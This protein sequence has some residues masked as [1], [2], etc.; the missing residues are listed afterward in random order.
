[1]CP[2]TGASVDW[3]ALGV[4]MYEMMAGQPPFEA[5]NEDDLFESILHDDV[6]YPVWLSKDA[7]S[8][9]KGFMTKNPSKRLGCVVA[10]GTEA[11]IRTHAFFRDMDWTALENRRVKPPFKP[12]I[13][14]DKD[15]REYSECSVCYGSLQKSKKDA[16]NF[17]AEFTKEDPVLT[18]V[19]MDV[20]RSINQEEFK[21][22]SFINADFNPARFTMDKNA[23]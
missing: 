20:V 6:L 2:C 19:N 18:P 22:F 3:W 8:I 21:G 10:H 23:T 9:L 5:D 1:M 13:V 11:A 4:L 15:G 12:K 14:S 16:L 7:V 17:D